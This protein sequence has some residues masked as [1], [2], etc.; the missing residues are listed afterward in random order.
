MGRKL[1]TQKVVVEE[2]PNLAQLDLN[3]LRQAWELHYACR[4]PSKMSRQL[5]VLAIGYRM[6]ELALGGLSQDAKQKLAAIGRQ[7][8]PADAGAA[9][10]KTPASRIRYRFRYKPGTRLLRE[11]QGV[12]HEVVVVEDGDFIHD[13][14]RY[15]SLSHIARTITGTNWSGPAFFGIR[16]SPT[17][18]GVS[19]G[20]SPKKLRP[21]EG[22]SRELASP[23]GSCAS[24]GKCGGA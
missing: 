24:I 2:L 22:S 3:A 21:V 4:A 5:L 7:T 14:R 23:E 15:K 11:W 18:A 6:Q 1:E 13:G 16:P 12:T 20:R 17:Q 8:A 9:N 19:G 10:A